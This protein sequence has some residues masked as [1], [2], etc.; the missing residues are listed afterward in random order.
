MASR[1]APAA[2]REN[3]LQQAARAPRTVRSIRALVLHLARETRDWAAVF[4]YSGV[5]E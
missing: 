3:L 1:P 2:P 4:S 5:A